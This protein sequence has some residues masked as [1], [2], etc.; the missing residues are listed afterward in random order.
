MDKRLH[1]LET[2]TAR[3]DDGKLYTVRGYEHL[4]RLDGAPDLAAEWQPTGVFEYRLSTGEAVSVDRAGTM[5]L[6]ERGLTLQR[7][8]AAAAAAA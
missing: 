6:V 1:Q 7:E 5:T 8:A 3:G 4:A 2:F